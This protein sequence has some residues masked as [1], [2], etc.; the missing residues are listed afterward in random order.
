M[1]S[2]DHEATVQCSTPT[3]FTQCS[4]PHSALPWRNS[5]M[6]Q[7]EVTVQVSTECSTPTPFTQCS[8][9]HSALPWRNSTMKQDEVTVQV[10]TECSTPTPFT[11]CSTPY[12]ALLW[13][14]STG[15]LG[16]CIASSPGLP[17]PL[18]YS[19]AGGKKKE[20]FKGEEGLV[21]LIT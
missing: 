4:T 14:N 19:N 6:K 10:S 12:S 13:R 1:A 5:T 11:Q 17:L 8:T 21:K 16:W 18:P 3:P 9:P 20:S 15:D 2:A 7:D